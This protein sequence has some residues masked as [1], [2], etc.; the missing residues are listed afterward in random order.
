MLALLHRCACLVPAP[1]PVVAGVVMAGVMVAGLVLTG[2]LAGCGADAP[3]GPAPDATEAEGAWSEPQ[4][5][6]GS[7]SPDGNDAAV[8]DASALLADL[9]ARVAEGLGH[10]DVGFQ[11]SVQ[12]VASV[13]WDLTDQGG[14]AALI[15]AGTQGHMQI[16]A[17]AGDVSRWLAESEGARATYQK[18]HP[19]DVAIHDAFLAA[20]ARGPEAYRTWCEEEAHALLGRHSEASRERVMRDRL[21][22]QVP[23]KRVDSPNDRPGDSPRERLDQGR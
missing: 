1:A 23:R 5:T 4:G 11:R 20:A 3:T 18:S 21:P 7:G 16:L 22:D 12:D 19:T 10:A 13:L 8:R 2:L 6:R 17:I 15:H 14:A 9:R